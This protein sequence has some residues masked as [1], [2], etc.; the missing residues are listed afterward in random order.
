MKSHSGCPIMC[1]IVK[2]FNILIVVLVGEG[3][4]GRRREAEEK[5]RRLGINCNEESGEG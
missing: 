3:L 5:G 2:Y 1:D 4:R